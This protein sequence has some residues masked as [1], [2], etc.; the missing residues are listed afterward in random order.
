[1][2][3]AA[4][5]EF[6]IGRLF[7]L[8][9]DAVVLGEADG[10]RIVLWNSA[11]EAVFGYPRSEALGMPLEEL[12]PERLRARHRAGLAG[13]AATGRGALIDSG[14]AIEVPARRKDGAEI[15]VELSLS[16][17]EQPGRAGRFVL[18]IVRDVTERERLRA[19]A[20][21][22]R[23]DGSVMTARRVAHELNN[24]LQLVS[25]NA[26]LLSAG[27]TG[28]TAERARKIV[29]AAAAAAAVIE[30]LRGIVR[31][32]EAAGPVGPMLD[33]DRSS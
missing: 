26:E 31:F 12:V 29:A 6:G 4:L 21:R 27:A 30:R 24:L 2:S 13:Y 3:E 25:M 28:D 23:L 19:E 16:P 14:G 11:A 17:I 33:L 18:A 10:G 5:S 20:E 32:E 8:I 9:R 22:A 7:D 1:M 15:T